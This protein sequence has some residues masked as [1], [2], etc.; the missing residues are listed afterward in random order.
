M[1]NIGKAGPNRYMMATQA[2]HL[3][4]D[5][6]SPEPDICVITEV[7]ENGDYIGR[8]LTGFGF[9]HVRFPKETTRELTPEELRE[10]ENTDLVMTNLS[11]LA[12]ETYVFTDI[13][14]IG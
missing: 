8:W 6:S 2:F 7:D 10:V 9:I 3:L 14:T 11:E 12:D 4:G 13:G 1:R 5:I